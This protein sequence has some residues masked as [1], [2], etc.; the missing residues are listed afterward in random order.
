MP[1]LH[2]IAPLIFE[3]ILLPGGEYVFSAKGATAAHRP[4]IQ[5]IVS[6]R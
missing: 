5:E 3:P 1:S 6:E 4:R 2:L